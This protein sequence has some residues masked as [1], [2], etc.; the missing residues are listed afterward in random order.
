[1][2]ADRGL[3]MKNACHFVPTPHNVGRTQEDDYRGSSLPTL[4]AD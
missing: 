2:T 3:W 1:M 4:K